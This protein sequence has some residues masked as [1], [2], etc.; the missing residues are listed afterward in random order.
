MS[1]TG[2]VYVNDLYGL[3]KPVVLAH[4]A[5]SGEDSL[6]DLARRL[7][8]LACKRYGKHVEKRF[9][10]RP[11]LETAMI[12]ERLAASRLMWYDREDNVDVNKV[13][14]EPWKLWPHVQEMKTDLILEVIR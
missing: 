9:W 7:L 8:N 2:L 13:W 4:Y 10:L 1:Y 3:Q 11:G 14:R 6:I 12:D 5:F